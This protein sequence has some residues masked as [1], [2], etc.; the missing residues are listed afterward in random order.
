MAVTGDGERGNGLRLQKKVG[1]KNPQLR[2][3]L[4]MNQLASF[5]GVKVLLNI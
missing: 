3:R 1:H 2:F 4:K 5:T